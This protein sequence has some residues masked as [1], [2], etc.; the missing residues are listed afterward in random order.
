MERRNNGTSRIKLP[1]LKR[2]DTRKYTRKETT[3]PINSQGHNTGIKNTQG[4]R[5]QSQ[6]GKKIKTRNRNSTV[7]RN[8]QEHSSRDRNKKTHQILV[9]KHTTQ[10]H[11]P[12]RNNHNH[13]NNTMHLMRKKP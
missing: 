12:K 4:T 7:E 9:Q 13:K 10:S 2:M 5:M 11:V 1:E 8:R 6:L 3:R